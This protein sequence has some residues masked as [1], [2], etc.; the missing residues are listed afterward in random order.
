MFNKFISIDVNYY[1]F[2][3]IFISIWLFGE[4]KIKYAMNSKF[5]QVW[6]LALLLRFIKWKR[7]RADFVQKPVTINLKNSKIGHFQKDT[8]IHGVKS[9]TTDKS[10]NYK[11]IAMQEKRYFILDQQIVQHSM[12]F[13]ECLY[14]PPSLLCILNNYPFYYFMDLNQSQ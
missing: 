4:G 8:L 6:K 7:G 3:E 13:S 2:K 10:I 9:L 12:L 5:K 1:S 11:N 14:Q